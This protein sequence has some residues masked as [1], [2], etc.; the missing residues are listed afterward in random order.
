MFG[1]TTSKT[2]KFSSPKDWN[3]MVGSIFSPS[4][5]KQREAL[6]I[7][8]RCAY[9][10]KSFDNFVDPLILKKV[11]SPPWFL[12]QVL[13]QNSSVTVLLDMMDDECDGCDEKWPTR[14]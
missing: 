7:P 1:T 11:S 13:K 4:R 5:R 2:Q 9:A 6:G 3:V 12:I 8:W 14:S 10:L